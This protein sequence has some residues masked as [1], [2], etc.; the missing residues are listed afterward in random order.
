VTET[1]VTDAGRRLVR[2]RTIDL[3][4]VCTSSCS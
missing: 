4:L 2:R 3:C 1:H